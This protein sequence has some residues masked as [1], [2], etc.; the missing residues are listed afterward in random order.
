VTEIV[1]V[2]PLD[3]LAAGTMHL[4]EWEDSEILVANCEGAILA[5][6]NRCSHD[7]GPLH[8]GTLDENGCT[9]KCPRHGSIFD[10]RSG[11]A[12]R[13]PADAP[14]DTF[15]VRVEDG[16]VRLELG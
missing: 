8:E 9:V 11:R 14:L 16:Q 15:P 10:L 12:V 2:C 5:M 4:V 6:Q 3:E 7:N 1:T 13:P